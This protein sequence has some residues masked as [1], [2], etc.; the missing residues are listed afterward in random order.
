MEAVSIAESIHIVRSSVCLCVFN[1]YNRRK[2]LHKLYL[3]ALHNIDIDDFQ[4]G[5]EENGWWGG[6]EEG[7]GGL[8]RS[9]SYG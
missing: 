4:W 5:R 9:L 2:N 3:I 6:E 8:G 1:V 7:G